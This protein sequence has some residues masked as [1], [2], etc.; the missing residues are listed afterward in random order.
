MNT[1][2][3]WKEKCIAGQLYDS[4]LSV[5]PIFDFRKLKFVELVPFNTKSKVNFF[6]NATNF[7]IQKFLNIKIGENVQVGIVELTC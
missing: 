2:P 5:F 6:L 7:I 1:E 3:I 4:H